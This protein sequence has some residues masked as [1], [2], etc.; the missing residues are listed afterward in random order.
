[1]TVNYLISLID[2]ITLMRVSIITV[3]FNSAKTLE[4]TILSVMH[5]DYDEIEHIIVDGGSVDGTLDIIRKYEDQISCFISEPDKGIYDA[6]NK[7]IALASG[8]IIGTLNSDDV[9]AGDTVISDVTEI[10]KV[11]SEVDILYADLWF[12]KNNDITKIVRR[13]RSSQ[14]HPSLLT[15]GI[16]PAHPTM[17]VKRRI[18]EKF[19]LYKTD[20]KISAD[21]E[22]IARIFYQTNVNYYYYPKVIIKM[23]MGGISTK[24]WQSLILSNREMLKACVENDIPTNIFKI[25]LKYPRKMIGFLFK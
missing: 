14:F 24:G 13:F 18:F 17:F 7:G 11:N 19:G 20:Y 6:M 2:I 22:F 9:Y 8:D 23:R 1:M 15:Y 16:A 10:L 5:Q 12:V 21:F 25:F 3:T 4:D